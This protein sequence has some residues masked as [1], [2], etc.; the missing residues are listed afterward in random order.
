M[1]LGA[2]A[3]CRRCLATWPMAAA[4]LVAGLGGRLPPASGVELAL[5]L[6]PATGEYVAVHAG[7]LPYSAGRT[8]I[9]GLILGVGLGRLAHR[10]LLAPGDAEVLA[11][12]V[13]VALP[14][15]LSAARY[16]LKE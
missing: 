8:L 1:R 12:A 10:Y 3:L 15:L 2:L 4:V 14:S 11:I 6:G 13:A 16:H 5:W 7:R 9:F